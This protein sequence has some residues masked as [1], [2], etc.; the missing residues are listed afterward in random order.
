M[1]S[2]WILWDASQI[3][4]HLNEKIQFSRRRRQVDDDRMNEPMIDRINAD[5]CI[6]P[7]RGSKKA[8]ELNENP[9]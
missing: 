7:L 2:N 3:V 4:V 9:S 6:K 1:I 5:C 8:F